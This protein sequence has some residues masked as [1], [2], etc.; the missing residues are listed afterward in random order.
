MSPLKQLVEI[1]DRFGIPYLIGGSH[2][3][4]TRGLDYR[5]TQDVDLV[6]AILPQQVEGLVSTLGKEWYADPQ[7]MRD[8]IVRGRAFNFIHIRSAEKFDIFPAAGAFERSQLQRATPEAIQFAGDPVVCN[9]AT[10]EDILLAKLR[11][12]KDGGQTSERQW[13]DIAGIVAANPAL[14]LVYL[15]QWASTLGVSELLSRALKITP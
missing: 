6:A 15:E 12:Y 10:A 3:S 5:Y 9:V 4:S 11:W 14:D 8:A 2:A 7:Q 13:R 1:L